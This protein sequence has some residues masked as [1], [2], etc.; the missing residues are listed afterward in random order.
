MKLPTFML[1]LVTPAKYESDSKDAAGKMYLYISLY[2]VVFVQS[3][4][5]VN[6][7]ITT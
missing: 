4:E 5:T 6:R 7:Y 1:K 2:I 3:G